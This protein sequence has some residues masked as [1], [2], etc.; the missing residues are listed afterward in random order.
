MWTQDITQEWE[1]VIWRV[2]EYET[3]LQLRQRIAFS[4]DDILSFNS[5]GCGEIDV[6]M[7]VTQKQKL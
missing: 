7:D 2:Y 5:V 3:G 1:N 6:N 4:I